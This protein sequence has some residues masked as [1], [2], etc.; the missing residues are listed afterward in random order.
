MA[1]WTGS[2]TFFVPIQINSA[3]ACANTTECITS[4]NGLGGEN[5]VSASSSADPERTLQDDSAAVSTFTDTFYGHLV[6]EAASPVS[7]GFDAQ[8]GASSSESKAP[9]PVTE[10]MGDTYL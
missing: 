4:A 10:T 3:G 6:R 8:H 5:D 9:L 7:H 1:W 2:S